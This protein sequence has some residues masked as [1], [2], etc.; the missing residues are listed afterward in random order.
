M[1]KFTVGEKVKVIKGDMPPVGT[2]MY[3]T[4]TN[5]GMYVAVWHSVLGKVSYSFEDDE[6]EPA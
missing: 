1:E 3:I 5:D 6:L 2:I 4:S